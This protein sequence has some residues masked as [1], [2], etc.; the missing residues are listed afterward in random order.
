MNSEAVWEY[1]RETI[2]SDDFNARSKELGEAH[3]EMVNCFESEI[4][5]RE[6]R[7]VGSMIV[8]GV[9]PGEYEPAFDCVF[10]RRQ[11]SDV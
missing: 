6:P 2:K 1:Y 9:I 11:P 3:W 5:V 10:K 4:M 8:S 7:N